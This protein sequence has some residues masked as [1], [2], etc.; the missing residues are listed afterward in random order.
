MSAAAIS[1]QEVTKRFGLLQAVAGITLDIPLGGVIGLLGPNGAGKTT[2]L[3]LVAGFLRPTS[4]HVKVLDI[5]V[6]NISDLRGRLATLPQD[7]Q[8][9]ANIPVVEQL[10]FF[11]RLNGR[12]RQ[13]AE[14]EANEALAIVGL[15][16]KAQEDARVLSHGMHKR[17][18][19]AQAF[20]GN[21]EV[22]L[23]DEPTA[24]LDATSADNV[25]ELIEQLR[26]TATIVVSSHNLPDIQKM[27]DMVAII[28]RGKLVEWS[29]VSEITR[30]DKMLRMAFARPLTPQ[31]LAAAEGCPS[32]TSIQPEADNVYSVMIDMHTTGQSQDEI[33]ADV[34]QRLVPTGAIP[35]SIT[36]GAALEERFRE[37]TSGRPPS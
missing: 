21:P 23:L 24:G 3:S 17:L 1:V 35:R 7:A 27:C 13:E 11:A 15:S 2:L 34:V 25:R 37:V 12:T 16:G 14:K 33:V 8:F 30:A 20:L 31:E 9:M 6:R 10:V 36:E 28:D 4:G 32:V 18:G 22:I 29:S 26:K 5:D 19:I